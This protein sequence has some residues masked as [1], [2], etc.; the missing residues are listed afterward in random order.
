MLTY[1]SLP[2][3]VLRTYENRLWYTHTH[4]HIYALT[5]IKSGPFPANSNRMQQPQSREQVLLNAKEACR[6]DNQFTEE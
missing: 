5:N 3:A 1:L 2:S 4:T 6:A